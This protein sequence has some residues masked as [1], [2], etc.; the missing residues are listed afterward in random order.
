MLSDRDARI[1]AEFTSGQPT[2]WRDVYRKMRCLGSCKNKDWYCWQDPNGRK[3]YPLESYHL[4]RLAK[5]VEAGRLDLDS[6]D[7]VPSEI[8][9]Q[10]YA[11]KH[12]RR[13]KEQKASE[14]SS[15]EP[16]GRSIN[17]NFL[18]SRSPQSS[19]LATPAGSPPL[20]PHPSSELIDPIVF[21]DLPLEVVAEEYSSW[22]KSQV[23][24]QR[25]KDDI[26]KARHIALENGLDL[27]Q[28]HGDQDPDFFIKH[29]VKIGVACCFFKEIRKWADEQGLGN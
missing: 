22:Q 11:R 29:R 26:D 6:H 14:Y 28:I 27:K 2:A 16:A 12:K 9:E 4:T 5:L 18:P 23:V 3:H 25:Y 19:V 20:L 15:V 24:S 1:D 8:R 10:L 17:I 13:E 7:D 21:P